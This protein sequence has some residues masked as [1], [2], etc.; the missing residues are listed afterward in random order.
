M[1]LRSCVRTTSLSTRLLIAGT[2]LIAAWSTP[3]L[4]Q[5]E[6]QELQRQLDLIRRQLANLTGE[7]AGPRRATSPTPAE[8]RLGWYE[9]HVAMMETSAYKD[10]NWQ[11]V[12]PTN[13][14]G[15]IT[16]V[17]VPTPKGD[18]YTIFIA[19]ASGGVW[20][21]KN[22]GITWEPV[23]E[24]G[25]STSVGD[26]HESSPVQGLSWQPAQLPRRRRHRRVS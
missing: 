17:A 21:T 12:G 7:T 25:P 4:G 5:Q 3:T 10:L 2:L 20:R 8:I 16:D 1:S 18:H 22:E 9:D 19:A 11:F 13:V 15:R 24:Q 23:F 14:S 6:V 26:L